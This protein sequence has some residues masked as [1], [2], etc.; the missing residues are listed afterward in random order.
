MTS[1]GAPTN[2]GGLSLT[3]ETLTIIGMFRL[4]RVDTT[5]HEIYMKVRLKPTNWAACDLPGRRCDSGCPYR[6]RVALKASVFYRSARKLAQSWRKLILVRF[7]C[8]FRR[9]WEALGVT[10][11]GW[12]L[13][14]KKIENLLKNQNFLIEKLQIFTILIKNLNFNADKTFNCLWQS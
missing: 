12:W 3:S 8:R 5:V 4:R 7:L 11:V 2:T 6:D 10:F 14:M 13:E 1:Y 9:R